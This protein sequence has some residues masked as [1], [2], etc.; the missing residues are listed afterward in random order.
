[1]NGLGLC[2]RYL[3]FNSFQESANSVLRLS[4]ALLWGAK[5]QFG[6][7]GV[8]ETLHSILGHRA[9]HTWERSRGLLTSSKPR[10]IRYRERKRHVR[11][12]IGVSHHHQRFCKMA[13]KLRAQ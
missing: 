5:N 4:I 1:M 12:R 10:W 13:E 3:P 2:V 6:V 11:V 9:S 8:K 7:C